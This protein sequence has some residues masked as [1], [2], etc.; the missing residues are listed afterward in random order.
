V[1]GVAGLVRYLSGLGSDQAG[2]VMPAET[3]RRTRQAAAIGRA[4]PESAGRWARRVGAEFGDRMSDVF[5]TVD[6]VLTPTMPV[7]P[8]RAG[9]LSRRGLAATIPLMLPC[10][11]F[12]APWNACGFPA[13]SLPTATTPGGLPIGMQFVAPPGGEATLLA[14]AAMLEAAIGWTARRPVPPT[15]PG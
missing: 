5:A 1:L 7:L 8:V 9:E 12:T 3:E 15:A 6:V 2:L 13:M 4:I 11:A 10:A 14:L